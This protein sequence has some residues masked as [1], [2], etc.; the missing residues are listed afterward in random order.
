[1]SI[2]QIVGCIAI[3]IVVVIFLIILKIKDIK[4]VLAKEMVFGLIDKQTRSLLKSMEKNR[5][6]SAQVRYLAESVMAVFSIGGRLNQQDIVRLLKVVFK[7]YDDMPVSIEIRFVRG[8]VCFV[9]PEFALV[10]TKAGPDGEKE[11]IKSFV[12]RADI[13]GVAEVIPSA[14][15]NN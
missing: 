8:F 9:Y 6:V 3:I 5:N 12:S 11:I 4:R 7:R 2:T 13:L 10:L 14:R 15:Y 1:M